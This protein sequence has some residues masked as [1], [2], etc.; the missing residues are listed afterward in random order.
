MTDPA[1]T[2]VNGIEFAYLEAG[3]DDGPLALCLHGFPVDAGVTHQVLADLA[4]AGY[5]VRVSHRDHGL[6]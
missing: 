4:A 1:R 6:D 3:P 2:T 5:P